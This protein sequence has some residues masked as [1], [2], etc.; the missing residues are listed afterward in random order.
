MCPVAQVPMMHATTRRR[1]WADAG[2]DQLAAP[3]VHHSHAGH[4]PAG[5]RR[6]VAQQLTDVNGK[7]EEGGD[8]RLRKI[9]F[10]LG[11]LTAMAVAL[12]APWKN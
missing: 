5:D 3:D 4:V 7:E 2:E 12:G 1:R 10:T 6:Q 8:M 11:W 9:A